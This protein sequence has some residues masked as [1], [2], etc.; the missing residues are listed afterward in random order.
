MEE[1]V[2]VERGRF[3]SK[4]WDSRIDNPNL[5]LKLKICLGIVPFNPGVAIQ[6]Y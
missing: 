1:H 5:K 4:N 3:N 6:A 2:T